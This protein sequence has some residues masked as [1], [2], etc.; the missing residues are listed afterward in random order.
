MKKATDSIFPKVCEAS[1]LPTPI[2]EY[3]FH[4]TRK[5]WV[6]WVISLE[7][8]LAVEVE[9]GVWIGG[10]H[11]SG[12][13]FVKDMEKYNAATCLGWRILRVQPKELCSATT[14]DMI[15]RALRA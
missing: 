6:D 8:N 14:M 2:P 5:W 15:A 13:G 12:S 9:G 11:T 1:G 10:R 4:P 7:Q 3:K